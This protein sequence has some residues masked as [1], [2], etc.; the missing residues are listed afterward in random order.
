MAVRCGGDTDTVGAIVGALVGTRV[1]PEG[2]PEAWLHNLWEWPRTRKW[3]TSLA[4]RLADDRTAS[5]LAWC[6]VVEHSRTIVAQHPVYGM[7][8][9][10]GFRRLLPPY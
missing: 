1:G 7:V 6:L 2:I 3:L 10:H 8:L 4:M 5:T 9:A